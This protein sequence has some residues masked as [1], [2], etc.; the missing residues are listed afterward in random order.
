MEIG[1]SKGI[2]V[3]VN[4]KKMDPVKLILL[5]N[6][7]GGRNGIGRVDIVENRLVGMK[8]RGVYESPAAVLLYAAHRELESLTLDRETFH[9]KN[10]LSGK[11]G[12]MIYNG[13]WYTT[14]RESLS[15]FIDQTQ[16]F[17][18]G[19]VSFELYKGNMKIASRESPHSLYWERLATFGYSGEQ[20]YDHKDSEGFIK[21]FG[22]PHTVESAL[23]KLH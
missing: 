10:S 22:L 5:L 4:G 19:T 23:R 16:K 20:I 21:L 18:S 9:F 12:E 17:M 3:S 14:L 7:I 6:K 11:M 1:F 15:V 8:S 13:L 2:P